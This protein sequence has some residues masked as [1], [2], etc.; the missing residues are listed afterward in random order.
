MSNKQQDRAF[1][2]FRISVG[3]AVVS[4]VKIQRNIRE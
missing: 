2:S 4:T 3:S 1:F